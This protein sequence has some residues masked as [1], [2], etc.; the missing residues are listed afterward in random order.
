MLVDGGGDDDNVERLMTKELN[1]HTHTPISMLLR[2]NNYHHPTQQKGDQPTNQ[3]NYLLN[4]SSFIIW[5]NIQ[6]FHFVLLSF[7]HSFSSV[8]AKKVVVVF[9]DILGIFLL[10]KVVSK[11]FSL[12]FVLQNHRN[13]CL[14]SWPKRKYL[15]NM[16][17]IVSMNLWRI[18]T[19]WWP[20]WRKTQNDVTINKFSTCIQASEIKNRINCEWMYEWY[21]L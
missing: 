14:V 12:P 15:L 21:L 1:L 6:V 17:R 13:S 9:S 3:P 16:T 2:N 19:K 18:A 8:N 5:K 11:H 7:S 20:K 10:A 4:N